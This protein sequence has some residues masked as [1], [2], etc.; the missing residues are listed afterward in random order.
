MV[1]LKNILSVA[2]V[3]LLA[4]NPLTF[5]VK[6]ALPLSEQFIL[7]QV[8]AKAAEARSRNSEQIETYNG[9]F[10]FNDAVNALKAIEAKGGEVVNQFGDFYIINMPLDSIEAIS[11]VPGISEIQLDR[12][13]RPMLMKA[14]KIG[15]VNAVHSGDGLDGYSFDGDG[16]IVALFDTGLDPN[17]VNFDGRVEAVY[18]Y[19]SNNPTIYTGA[20]VAKFTTDKST[21]THGTHVLGI[22]TG[23]V[24]KIGK[25]IDYVYDASGNIRK[26]PNGSPYVTSYTNADN[27]YKGVAPGARVVVACGQLSSTYI[28]DAIKRI[29]EYAVEQGVPA[30]INLSLGG[31]T[32]PRD[33]SDA[34]PSLI[35]Q[36]AETYPNTTICISS[37]NEGEQKQFITKQNT[38]GDLT[39]KTFVMP[40]YTYY[41]Q[42]ATRFANSSFS[43]DVYADDNKEFTGKVAFYNTSGTLITSYD[44]PKS[45]LSGSKSLSSGATSG[46]FSGGT[47]TMQRG[48]STNNRYLATIN[49]TNL[50]QGA[51]T[52]YISLE[53]TSASNQRIDAFINNANPSTAT[54]TGG[55]FSSN[56]RE[57]WSEPDGNMS[58]NYL[59]CAKG[60]VSVGAMTSSTS[61]L[62]L[63]NYSYSYN[64]EE[65]DI[66]SFSSFG[67]LIDGRSIPHFVTPGHVIASSYSSLYTSGASSWSTDQLGD[68]VAQTTVGNKNYYWG[69]MSGTSMACPFATG[70]LAL[71]QQA[72]LQANGKP[73]TTA[74]LIEV[75]QKTAIND[76]FVKAGNPIQWGA[77]KL[78]TY[79]AVKEILSTSAIGKVNLDPREEENAFM[80]RLNGR[81]LNVFVAGASSLTLDVYG[82]A[83]Q[84][85]VS[86]SARGSELDHSLADM[87]TGMY[88]I[89]VTTPEGGKYSKKIILK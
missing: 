46:Y 29:S 32:G 44:I 2:A 22:M 80:Y 58:V 55:L 16:V 23:S 47:L 69:M 86:H 43:I 74:Q 81:D 71:F 78:N 15:D 33:G 41:E 67:K 61:Y 52:A 84:H 76:D 45:S 60:V 68:L 39:F 57:G 66:A 26:A 21:E 1:H 38:T 27:P 14:K 4:T 50:T 48:V 62:S 49:L 88:V 82:I 87:G 11:D 24:D 70:A 10:K 5:N 18:H 51:S 59:A 17:H 12:E 31:N 73:M 54:A 37:G 25:Y 34:W 8:R 36:L 7:D 53:I 85:L 28:S 20:N 9:I 42:P 64:G 83:G 75:A 6:A 30:I 65:G 40:F 35:S 63:N 89:T 13:L 56:G 72:A 3:V 19:A 79:G 77:G